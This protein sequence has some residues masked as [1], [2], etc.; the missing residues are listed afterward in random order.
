MSEDT[1]TRTP[2]YTNIHIQTS[3]HAHTNTQRTLIDAIMDLTIFAQQLLFL[4]SP[5]SMMLGHP[6]MARL[7]LNIHVTLKFLRYQTPKEKQ[8][9][10]MTIVLATLR[11]PD[12]CSK[13]PTLMSTFITTRLQTDGF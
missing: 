1:S 8:Y 7:L 12:V 13:V 3:S 11:T 4:V 9:R 10:D 5:L 2:T 6:S